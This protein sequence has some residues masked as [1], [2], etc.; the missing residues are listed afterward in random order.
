[1]ENKF[2]VGTKVE[3]LLGGGDEYFPGKIVKDNLNKTY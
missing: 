2:K 1:M 3:A